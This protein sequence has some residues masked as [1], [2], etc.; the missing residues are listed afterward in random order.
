M[1]RAAIPIASELVAFSQFPNLNA[2]A[3]NRIRDFYREWLADNG[4]I[5]QMIRSWHVEFF[6]WVDNVH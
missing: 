4:V 3:E 2:D 5:A 1:N 6:Q